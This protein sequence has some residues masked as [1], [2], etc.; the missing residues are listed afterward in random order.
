MAKVDSLIHIHT[1]GEVVNAEIKGTPKELLTMLTSVM[2]AD[3]LVN[4]IIRAAVT[5]MDE[6]ESNT[7]KNK[8]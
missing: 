5:Y 8:E 6:E 3:S 1:V 4:E 2:G 7:F